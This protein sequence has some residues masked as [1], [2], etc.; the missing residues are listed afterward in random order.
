MRQSVFIAWSIFTLLLAGCS[1][2]PSAPSLVV[3]F[4]LTIGCSLDLDGYRCTAT[5]HG[6]DGTRKDITGL[7][8]WSTSDASL[9]T[10]NSVGLVTVIRAGEI[11]IRVEYEG[12]SAFMIMNLDVGGLRRYYRAL[13]GFVTDADT[14]A[15]L[16]GVRVEVRSGPN[17]GRAAT[18]GEDG[19][20]QLYDLE[21]GSFVVRFT[22]A[23]YATTERTI[24][25]PGDRFTSLDV[26]LTK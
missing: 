20:Y 25:L 22:R 10:V 13:S 4:E 17:A 11:A 8:K 15:K 24:D 2:S 18:T 7:A 14:R 1:E 12:A 16:A 26:S 9:A 6:S 21:T 19:A 3:S 5:A 23:G